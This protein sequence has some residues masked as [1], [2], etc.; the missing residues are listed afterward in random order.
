MCGGVWLCVSY[1]PVFLR[2]FFGSHEES[3]LAF[4]LLGQNKMIHDSVVT[5]PTLPAEHPLNLGYELDAH[6][7]ANK[8]AP[9]AWHLTWLRTRNF[10]ELSL[11]ARRSLEGL[12]YKH[13]TDTYAAD[14]ER[15]RLAD[16][17]AR[18][19]GSVV[20]FDGDA[21]LDDD[22]VLEPDDEPFA[23]AGDSGDDA[24]VSAPRPRATGDA[25]SRRSAAT[26]HTA[27]VRVKK[28]TEDPFVLDERGFP[29]PDDVLDADGGHQNY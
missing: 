6:G 15:S 24:L 28:I 22:I 21:Q 27:A 16:R 17:A 10:W 2:L 1:R 26:A 20:A 19:L 23:A 13:L 7:E 11:R 5:Q 9:A 8:V 29:L 3:W 25:K 12:E 18:D 4:T 14:L